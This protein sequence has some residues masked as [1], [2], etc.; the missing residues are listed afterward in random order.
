MNDVHYS[1]EQNSHSQTTKP[2]RRTAQQ[3]R[4][5]NLHEQRA[6]MIN[7]CHESGLRAV[8]LCVILAAS[9]FLPAII[10]PRLSHNRDESRVFPEREHFTTS[11]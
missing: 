9:D 8:R 11:S 7:V 5:L 1:P 3:M 10:Q 4:A 6:A 2:E